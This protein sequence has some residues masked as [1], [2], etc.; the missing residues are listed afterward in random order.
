[1]GRYL[2]RRLLVAIPTLLGLSFLI[3]TL[4]SVAPG[5]AAE[6]YARRRAGAHEVTDADIAAARVQLGLDRPFLAQ[7]AR[8]LGRA[9]RADLGVSFSN[10]QPVFAQIRDRLGATVELA[11]AALSLIVVAGVTLGTLAALFRGRLPDHFLRAGAL[12]GASVPSFFLAYLLII[13][14]V[15]NLRLLPVG[16]RD[17]L[18][19]LIM[20]AMVVAALP[21]AVTSRLLRSSLLEVFGE[22]HLRTARSKGLSPS[23][24]VVRHALRNGAIPVVTYLGIILGN[25]L[26]GVIVAEFIF[27][28]PGLGRL[29]FQAISQRDYPTIQAV[30]VFAGA[31]FI[32][33]NLLV[34]VAYRLLD[35]RIRLEANV[36]SG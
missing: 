36:E 5:D 7:Y 32:F 14:F 15:R 26:E 3:F 2:A 4:V 12:L 27:A 35:P 18:S 33:V 6:E 20:P 25:L 28:W 31:T 30:V 24:T 8:W 17:G 22:D 11:L 10:G 34:D 21:T 13:L 23:V 29:T 19:S 16:G 1:M 9:V